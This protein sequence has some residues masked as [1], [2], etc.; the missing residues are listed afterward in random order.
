MYKSQ[1]AANILTGGPI[2]V[3]VERKRKEREIS[4]YAKY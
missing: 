2:G 3:G 4:K 1:N